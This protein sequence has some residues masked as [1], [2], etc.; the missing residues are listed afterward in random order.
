M[1]IVAADAGAGAGAGAD[2]VAGV[3]LGVHAGVHA[4]CACGVYNAGV[5]CGCAMRMCMWVCIRA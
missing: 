1:E 5:L 2:G 3:H 4:E